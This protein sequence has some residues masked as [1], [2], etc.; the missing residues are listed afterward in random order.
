MKHIL[1]CKKILDT[2]CKISQKAEGRGQRAEGR[3]QR[4]E[5][6][7]QKAEGRGQRAEGRGQGAEGREQK[8]EGK[9][10]MSRSLGNKGYRT[11]YK[12]LALVLNFEF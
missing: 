7:G 12:Q 8:A 10:W 5:G 2:G 3:G 11:E 6:R 4:A 9:F 1:L